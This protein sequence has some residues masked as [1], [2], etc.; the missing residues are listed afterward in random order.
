MIRQNVVRI[1]LV[2]VKLT[3][4]RFAFCHSVAYVQFVKQCPMGKY[5]LSLIL[6]K[7]LK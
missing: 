4:V 6:F 3:K 2:F 7:K 5:H 1:S